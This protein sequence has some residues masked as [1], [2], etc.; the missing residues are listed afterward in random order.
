MDIFSS[1]LQVPLL[2]ALG[3]VVL[4]GFAERSGI[5]VISLLKKTLKLNGNGNGHKLEGIEDKLAT[6]QGNHLD[7]LQ[8]GIDQLG[9]KI[10]KL[11]DILTELRVEGIKCRKE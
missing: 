8:K 3:V 2:Q 7:H 5:P 4:I 1:I 9:N 11:G 6:I 10:D